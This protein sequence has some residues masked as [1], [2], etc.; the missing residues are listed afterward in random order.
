M[1]RRDDIF[2][3]LTNAA[4]NPREEVI[5]ETAPDP[6]PRAAANAGTVSLLESSTDYLTLEADVQS[7]SILLVTDTY[8]KGWRARPLAGTVQSLYRVLPAD[9]CLRAIPLAAGHHHLRLEYQ[10]AGYVIGKWVSI[11]SLVVFMG[12]LALSGRKRLA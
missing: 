9:Y 3:A 5:L 10:P 1:P 8:A 7:P 6:E 4:F 11:V 12:L 2:A